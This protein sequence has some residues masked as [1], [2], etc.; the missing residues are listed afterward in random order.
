[1]DL[2]GIALALGAAVVFGLV[3]VVARASTLHPLTLAAASY[4]VAGLLLVPLAVRARPARRDASRLL[5]L[6]LA[7][8]V[9]APVALFYGLERTT[10][11]NASLLLTLEMVLTATLAWVLLRERLGRWGATGAGLL[12]LAALL[13]PLGTQASGGEARSLLGD[14][15]VVLAALAWAVDNTLSTALS[16]RYE[17]HHLV[18]WKGLVGGL[19]VGCFALALGDGFDVPA[20]AWPSVLFIGLVGIGLATGLLVLSFRRLG[21]TRTVAVFI[22]GAALTGVAGGA[23]ALGEAVG[24]IHGLSAALVL[25]GVGVMAREAAH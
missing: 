16:H 5:A 2:R 24:L 9:V 25:V 12:L 18:A 1:M 19:V 20:S 11:S 3:N 15:L 22:P 8:G 4:L 17:P 6:G 7:G 23:I 21:A 14:G 10:A 13:V